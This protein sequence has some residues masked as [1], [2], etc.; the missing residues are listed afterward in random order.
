MDLDYC[1]RTRVEPGLTRR[2]VLSLLAGAVVLRVA[3]VSCG[4]AAVV[5]RIGV[6]IVGKPFQEHVVLAVAKFVE[7]EFGVRRAGNVTPGALRRSSYST[8]D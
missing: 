7:Q 3:A 5:L 1:Y 4:R 2:D 8:G 6:Q